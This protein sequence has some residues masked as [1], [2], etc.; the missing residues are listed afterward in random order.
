MLRHERA[1]AVQHDYFALLGKVG[2]GSPY[3]HARHAIPP[4]QVNLSRQLVPRPELSRPDVSADVVSYLRP[5]VGER[6][7]VD[8][9]AP[10]LAAWHADMLTAPLTCT[11]P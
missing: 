5:D 9:A 3:G 8:P 6:G 2:N 11:N 4:R 1:P 10:V 7:R